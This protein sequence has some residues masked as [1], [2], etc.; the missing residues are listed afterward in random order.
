MLHPMNLST[1]AIATAPG[2]FLTEACARGNARGSLRLLLVDDCR[3]NRMLVTAVLTRWGVVP[4][5]ACNGEQAVL[6]SERQDFYIV[7]MDILMP[8]MDGV[9]S[10]GGASRPMNSSACPPC[11]E[12]SRSS[13]SFLSANCSRSMLIRD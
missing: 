6:I 5:M 2:A 9:W 13:A 7:L 8:V 1:P 12:G 3:T 4:T 11:W 10:R